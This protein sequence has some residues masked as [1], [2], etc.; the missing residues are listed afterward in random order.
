M[1]GRHSGG[2][3]TAGRDA[4][5]L[6]GEQRLRRSGGRRDIIVISVARPCGSHRGG[7]DCEL[8]R[9]DREGAGA[10]GSRGGG[11]LRGG[12]NGSCCRG[13]VAEKETSTAGDFCFSVD[14]MT[15]YLT[16]LM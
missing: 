3:S 13:R 1:R 2:A 10:G 12:T 5:A 9:S 6:H 15:E 7:A 16:N 14:R 8:R 4:L 11:S